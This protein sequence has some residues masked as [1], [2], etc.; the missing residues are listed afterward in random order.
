VVSTPTKVSWPAA[1]T[2]VLHY[3]YLIISINQHLKNP[4][5][6]F[7]FSSAV[8]RVSIVA[9]K[10]HDQEQLGEE[11][12]SFRLY[13]QVTLQSLGKVKAGAQTG[14]GLGGRS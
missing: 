3:V 5:L 6:S 12:V 11:R 14:Q 8:G 1:E 7:L 13:F 9:M 4:S 10:H 2:P